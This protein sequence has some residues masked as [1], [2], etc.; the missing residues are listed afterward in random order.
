MLLATD[1]VNIVNSAIICD[2]VNSA[3]TYANV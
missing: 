3:I 2:N 1:C